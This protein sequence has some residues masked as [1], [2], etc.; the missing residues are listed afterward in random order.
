MPNEPLTTPFT[1]PLRE[2][3]RQAVAD[4]LKA[5]AADMQ[6]SRA[7]KLGEAEPVVVYRPDEVTP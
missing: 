6:A 1:S 2:Q 3:D 5:L 7:M 4:L